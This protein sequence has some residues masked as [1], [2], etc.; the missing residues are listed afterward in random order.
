MLENPYVF[1]VGGKLY[2]T[3]KMWVVK[4]WYKGFGKGIYLMDDGVPFTCK[5]IVEHLFALGMQQLN[6]YIASALMDA[7]PDDFEFEGGKFYSSDDVCLQFLSL[8]CFY[9][10]EEEDLTEEL[11]DAELLL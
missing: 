5:T 11:L 8:P 3:R 4:T 10:Y 1:N 6:I 9:A 7:W 2:A